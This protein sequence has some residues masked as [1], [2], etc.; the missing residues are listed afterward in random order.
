MKINLW[1][2]IVTLFLFFLLNLNIQ[3][4]ENKLQGDIYMIVEVP[5]EFPGGMDSFY[6]FVMDSLIYPEEARKQ[7]YEGIVFVQFI[8]N[9]FGSVVHDSIKVVRGVHPLLDKEVIRVIK[10]SPDWSPA[11]LVKGGKEVSQLFV[12]PVR[13]SLKENRKKG[14]KK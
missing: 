11:Q 8:I 4:Q 2:L 5:A 1:R 13:F 7:S 10:L 12:F 3:A 9:E 14:K 6:Q